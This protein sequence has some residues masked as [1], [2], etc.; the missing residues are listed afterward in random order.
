MPDL[1]QGLHEPAGT[2]PRHRL[3]RAF[4][5][6]AARTSCELLFRNETSFDYRVKAEIRIF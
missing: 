4:G 1:P 2:D 5:A 3:R 6:V